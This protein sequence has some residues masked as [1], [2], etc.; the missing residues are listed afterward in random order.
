MVVGGWRRIAGR[1]WSLG[2]EFGVDWRASFKWKGRRRKRSEFCRGREGE[3]ETLLL[4][5][6]LSLKG[7]QR[8]WKRSGMLV[9]TG[10]E[11]VECGLRDSNPTVREL[12]LD[13]R[14]GRRGDEQ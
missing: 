14:S 10:L 4:A 6:V 12:L 9:L 2:D 11:G 8:C 13:W 3:L 5:L 7:I 1:W